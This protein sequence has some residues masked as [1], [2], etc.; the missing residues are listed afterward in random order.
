MTFNRYKVKNA[1][2]RDMAD[3][4]LQSV[5]HMQQRQLDKMLATL[6]AVA[7]TKPAGYKRKR[8]RQRK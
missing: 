8:P 7:V 5:E 6:G 2:P 4:L 3:Y 1:A